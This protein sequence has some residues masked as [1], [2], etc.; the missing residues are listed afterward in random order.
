MFLN[1]DNVGAERMSSGRLFQA[2]GPATPNAWLP[3]CSKSPRAAE[4]E[5][6]KVGNSGN[7]NKHLVQIPWCA[8]PC[9][10]LY[11]S[12][13]SLNEMRSLARSQCRWSRS[14]GVTWWRLSPPNI[15]LAK[16]VLTRYSWS[17]STLLLRVMRAKATKAPG[18]RLLII[19]LNCR[20]LVVVLTDHWLLL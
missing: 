10:A 4:R 19:S 1:V 16:R 9:I 11:A 18:S 7:W 5:S 20:K 2:T 6:R 3:S 12:R 13:Q 8:R 17:N 14:S 15:T